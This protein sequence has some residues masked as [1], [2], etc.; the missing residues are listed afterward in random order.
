M[1]KNKKPLL[2]LIAGS[3]GSGKS[4][5]AQ[6]ILSNIPSHLNSITICQ[7]RYY[8]DQSRS[9]VKIENVNFD[10]PNAFD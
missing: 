4:T 9:N 1:Q 2:I 8:I 5:I 6:K 10:H 7:D 3:S